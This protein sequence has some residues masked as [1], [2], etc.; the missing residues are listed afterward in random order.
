MRF[1]TWKRIGSERE[2]MQNKI[3][4][5][6]S[7]ALDTATMNVDKLNLGKQYIQRIR[8]D[9]LGRNGEESSN[10]LVLCSV[11]PERPGLDVDIRF[12]KNGQRHVVINFSIL[13]SPV[14][15]RIGASR[16]KF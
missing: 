9:T 2:A 3:V 13:A 14:T 7:V 11:P 15:G 4:A 8:F 5:D 16:E 10:G 6:K 1:S 12:V